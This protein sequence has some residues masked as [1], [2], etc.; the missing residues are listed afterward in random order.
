MT[1]QEY[2]I[3][4]GFMEPVGATTTFWFMPKHVAM[5]ISPERRVV[6]F[7]TTE[8]LYNSFTAEDKNA[9]DGIPGEDKVDRRYDEWCAGVMNN[10]DEY[11]RV[12]PAFHKIREAAKIIALANW[13]LAEKINVDLSGVSQEKWDAPNKVLGFLRTG[14]LYRVATYMMVNSRMACLMARER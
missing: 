6:T 8:M 4:K 2:L 10:Y 12:L 11:A 5:E 13:L 3:H 14:Q 7:S 9:P 1:Q